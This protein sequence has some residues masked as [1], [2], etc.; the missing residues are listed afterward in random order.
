M[1]E[2]DT[3]RIFGWT[4]G[5]GYRESKERPIKKQ[6]TETNFQEAES[7]FWSVPGDNIHPRLIQVLTETN[8]SVKETRTSYRFEEGPRTARNDDLRPQHLSHC[9]SGE[10]PVR[11]VCVRKKTGFSHRRVDIVGHRQ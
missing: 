10:A 3:C 8:N 7:K 4:N 11:S 2:R 6:I 1:K 5:L 9:C